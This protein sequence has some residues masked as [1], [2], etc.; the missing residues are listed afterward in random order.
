MVWKI[1]NGKLNS[2]TGFVDI[3]TIWDANLHVLTHILNDIL[4]FVKKKNNEMPCVSCTS[5]NWPEL[6]YVLGKMLKFRWTFWMVR[7]E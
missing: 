7:I 5:Y 1:H 4:V 3:E 6:V 2:E